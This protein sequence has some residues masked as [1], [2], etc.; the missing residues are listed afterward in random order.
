MA[1]VLP[2]KVRNAGGITSFLI[3]HH[4]PPTKNKDAAV[5]I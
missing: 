3:D 2:I 4:K 1:I 5:S